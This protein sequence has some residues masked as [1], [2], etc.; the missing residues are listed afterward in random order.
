MGVLELGRLPHDQAQRREKKLEKEERSARPKGS[1]GMVI[2]R[3]LAGG[4]EGSGAELQL[5]TCLECR[6]FPTADGVV[7]PCM[8]STPHK[9]LFS[10]VCGIETSEVVLIYTTNRAAETKSA[11]CSPLSL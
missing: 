1:T 4:Q 11:K 10:M 3:Q 6:M 2:S 9:L 7:L 5:E 8:D